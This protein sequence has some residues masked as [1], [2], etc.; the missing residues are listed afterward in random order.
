MALELNDKSRWSAQIFYRGQKKE[1]FGDGDGELPEDEDL[2]GKLRDLH[3]IW[4]LPRA[5]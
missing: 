4:Q 2:E 5:G 1:L 3:G